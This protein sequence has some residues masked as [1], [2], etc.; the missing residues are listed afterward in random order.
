MNRITTCR[1]HGIGNSNENKDTN[2]RRQSTC[3]CICVSS[4][5]RHPTA[6]SVQTTQMKRTHSSYIFQ[7]FVRSFVR[8]SVHSFDSVTRPRCVMFHH[9]TATSAAPLQ[10]GKHITEML[11]RLIFFLRCKF[12]IF[13][14][15]RSNRSTFSP[16]TSYGGVQCIT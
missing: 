7:H 13:T 11:R 6:Q 4:A 16:N 8:S 2:D 9:Q 14:A 12:F 3:M 5:I 10:I 15:T 1:D